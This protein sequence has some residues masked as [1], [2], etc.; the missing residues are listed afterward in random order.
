MLSIDFYKRDIRFIELRSQTSKKISNISTANWKKSNM[1]SLLFS[2]I[3]VCTGICLSSPDSTKNTKDLK[4]GTHTPLD[5]IKKRICLF[6]RKKMTLRTA[7]LK[8]GIE[9]VPLQWFEHIFITALLFY[10]FL[11]FVFLI[12]IHIMLFSTLYYYFFALLFIS[13]IIVYSLLFV[14]NPLNMLNT[15]LPQVPQTKLLF[16]SL[17]SKGKNNK[18]FISTFWNAVHIA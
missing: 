17:R 11:P 12:M 16:L 15:Y 1:Y 18:F 7:S 5:P 13:C 6:Y 14:R 9:M 3:Y 4:S 2:P 10:Y 8:T